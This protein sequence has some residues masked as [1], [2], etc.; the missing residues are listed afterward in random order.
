[1]FQ[2]II[3]IFLFGV[4]G[5]LFAGMDQIQPIAQGSS[6]LH[7][8]FSLGQSF[9]PKEAELSKVSFFIKG[10]GKNLKNNDA[11]ITL[12]VRTQWH[13]KILTSSSVPVKDISASGQWVDFK[14]SPSLNV[15]P[16]EHYILRLDY[17]GGVKEKC[18]LMLAGDYFYNLYPNGKAL[19]CWMR[20]KVQKNDDLDF[21]FKT[22]SPSN[23]ASTKK[24][25][26]K[27]I[28]MI[29][30]DYSDNFNL[31]WAG[32]N[33]FGSN[34]DISSKQEIINALKQ[35]KVCGADGVIWR[36]SYK[37]VM[38]H[39]KI[40]KVFSEKDS[41]DR[42]QRNLAKAI[43]ECDPLK[44]AVEEGHKLGLKVYAWVLLN[45]S[46]GRG[47][48]WE[49]QLIEHPEYQWSSRDGKKFLP[50]VACYAYK[51]VR[52][53]RLAQ[54]KELMQYGIDGL[55]MS[56]RSHTTAFGRNVLC[57][58]GFNKPVAE[59]FKQKYGVDIIKNFN[60]K[61]DADRLIRLRGKLM[62]KFYREVKSLRDKEFP[63]IK[64]AADLS[65]VPQDWPTWVK[66]NLLD[67]ILV[68]S[69]SGNYGII[70]SGKEYKNI[71]DFY[72]NAVKKMKGKT[73]ILMWIQVVNYKTKA[74]HV[75][76]QIY[77]DL[78]WLGK[79]KSAGGTFHEHCGALHEP[80]KY[81]PYIKKAL[82]ATW[83]K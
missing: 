45:D 63:K 73:K 9:T 27:K 52:K 2:R 60:Q 43:K 83:N 35:I 29:N 4:S 7:S 1:M 6:S 79:S 20:G 26:E 54:M 25:K 40:R 77:N 24:K 42:Y 11:Q 10:P 76:E 48:A 69:V 21:A 82:E 55:F 23:T 74:Y 47:K 58:F 39:S 32:P 37:G 30:V 22:Y 33:G 8:K 80:K 65:H 17:K 12:S 81:W 70:P 14:I 38:Y 34:P 46:G 50:G 66:E 61:R 36:V 41:K 59:A 19:F 56:T 49:K 53:N 15:T 3:I 71:P 78:Y 31:S 75:K 13:G 51:A 72:V 18:N 68:D 28:F 5:N 16:K 67:Y 64:L 44:I 57:S 62:N